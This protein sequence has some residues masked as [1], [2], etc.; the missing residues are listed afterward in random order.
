[1]YKDALDVCVYDVMRPKYMPLVKNEKAAMIDK[2]RIIA[3]AARTNGCGNCG[4]HA[5]TAFTYLYDHGVR[6]LDYMSLKGADHAFVVIDARVEIRAT[7]VPG[8]KTPWCV[9]RGGKGSGVM[10]LRGTYEARHF[11][12]RMSGLLAFTGVRSIHREG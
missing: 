3:Q 8:E 6:P 9:T 2:I 1:M 10:K 11:G 7:G 12:T 4:E 5:A